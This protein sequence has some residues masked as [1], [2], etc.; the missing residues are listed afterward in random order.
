MK[1]LY[2]SLFLSTACM[3]STTPAPESTTTTPVQAPA[4]KDAVPPATEA[5]HRPFG[6]SLLQNLPED[7]N[8][9]LSPFSVQTAL[10]MTY[11][12]AKE[13]T[14]REME[15]VLGLAPNSHELLAQQTAAY[16]K[17]DVPYTLRIANRVYTE[18]SLELQPT[19][20]ETTQKHYGS[21]IQS[22][23]FK[24]NADAERLGINQ[25]VSDQ[26]ETRIPELLPSGSVDSLT[27]LILVNA[28]YFLADWASP[29]SPKN[30]KTGTFYERGTTETNAQMMTQTAKFRYADK[31]DF[32]AIELPY[33]GEELSMILVLP[34]EKDGW[35]SL[36]QTLSAQT[37]DS[38]FD[39]FALQKVRL[40]MPKFT[41]EYNVELAE[42]LS[43]M[44]MPSAFTTANFT[45][46]ANDPTLNISQVFHKTFVAVDE[47][48]TEAAAATAAVV[49]A[50]GASQPPVPFTADRPFFFA[51]C[52]Q[53]TKDILF[54]GQLVT[55]N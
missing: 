22:V 28:L 6:F 5:N 44:G 14:A 18:R 39:S 29:F 53:Q 45:G 36:Q 13:Q 21:A 54:L 17:A 55:P 9:L 51:I 52:H 11:A 26:T 4:E 20:I 30:T 33:T 48:G 49:V 35:R 3:K 32:Q 38:V 42:T 50:R 27:R 23:D 25:W 15:T 8:V 10:A 37:I 24:A 2:L 1:P 40:T 16:T 34:K 41:V 7:Q 46:M 31:E 47:Q 19:F 43:A 12:G